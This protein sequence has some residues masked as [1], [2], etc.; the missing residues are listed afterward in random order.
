MTASSHH[1]SAPV[2]AQT[3]YRSSL[4]EERVAGKRVGRATFKWEMTSVVP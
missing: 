2:W 4:M 1:G 3:D